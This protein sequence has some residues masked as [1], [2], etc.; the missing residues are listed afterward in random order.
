M[1][2]NG[3]TIMPP[4]DARYRKERRNSVEKDKEEK[5]RVMYG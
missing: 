4:K 2:V 3:C 1:M 5:R